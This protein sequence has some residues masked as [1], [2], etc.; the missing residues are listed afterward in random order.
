MLGFVGESH[1]GA[2]GLKIRQLFL[3]S[4]TPKQL[5]SILTST[6]RATRDVCHFCETKSKSNLH[7]R[8]NP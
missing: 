2:V 8:P 5:A 6:L 4:P 3:A 1:S 7:T